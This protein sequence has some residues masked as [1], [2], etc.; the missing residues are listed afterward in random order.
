MWWT[1]M[2]SFATSAAAPAGAGGGVCVFRGEP[3][4][5]GVR[6]RKTWT[7]LSSGLLCVCRGLTRGRVGRVQREEDPSVVLT[8]PCHPPHLAQPRPCCLELPAAVL[9][10]KAQSQQAWPSPSHGLAPC[11]RSLLGSSKGHGC[12]KCL[13]G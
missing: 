7:Q 12:S 1:E 5:N 11:T 4:G 8:S 2:V 10:G 6:I 13:P 9:P 3:W